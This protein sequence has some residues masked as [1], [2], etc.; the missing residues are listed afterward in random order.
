MSCSDKTAEFKVFVDR[1][2]ECKDVECGA[3]V[4]KDVASW[5][6]ENKNARGDEE[7]AKEY[8]EKLA[9]CILASGVSPEDLIEA[10]KSF[11]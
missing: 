7:K 1:S 2:C 9:T 5:A 10:F 6:K 8:G 4:L 3:K 11:Q